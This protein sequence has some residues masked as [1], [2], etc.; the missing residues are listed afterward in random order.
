MCF[1]RV[2]W[3]LDSNISDH[4]WADTRCILTTHE[5][6]HLAKYPLLN[7]DG[8]SSTMAGARLLGGPL[9]AIPVQYIDQQMALNLLVVG[10]L[11]LDLSRKATVDSPSNAKRCASCGDT[12][13]TRD[14]IR[15]KYNDQRESTTSHAI[16]ISNFP[17]APP[18]TTS[19]T[20][21]LGNI[22]EARNES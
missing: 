14:H 19:S 6:R 11:F 5:V 12:V 10:A 18:T 17:A 21:I 7:L 8:I 20:A 22:G 16:N 15:R 4:L 9:L 3:R 13:Q 2:P 1:A